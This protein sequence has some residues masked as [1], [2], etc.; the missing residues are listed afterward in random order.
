MA[1]RVRVATC[2]GA[3]TPAPARATARRTCRAVVSP[4]P[5]PSTAFPAPRDAAAAS[6]AR[7]DRGA[8]VSPCCQGLPRRP[9]LP[10]RRVGRPAARAARSGFSAADLLTGAAATPLL[11][12][13]RRRPWVR[14][15][16]LPRL[17]QAA[18]TPLGGAPA[19]PLLRRPRR[20][21]RIWPR[22]PP[23]RVSFPG[24]DVGTTPLSPATTW[25]RPLSSGV[26]S[27]ALLLLPRAASPLS[28]QHL[29]SV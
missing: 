21:P 12:R 19:P 5:P 13:T 1:A 2:A 29:S 24:N 15:D 3:A 10:G 22:R 7:L 23:L 6:R 9:F 14:H 20:R 28:S 25:A 8:R 4:P 26:A 17:S 16:V 11:R 18:R 27:P